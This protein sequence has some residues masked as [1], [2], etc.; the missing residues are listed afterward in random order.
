LTATAVLPP[1][2]EPAGAGRLNN[3]ADLISF[4][5]SCADANA[6]DKKI[7]AGINPICKSDRSLGLLKIIFLLNL[8]CFR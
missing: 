8:V 6:T 1:L 2:T 3:S 4:E 7:N 5:L